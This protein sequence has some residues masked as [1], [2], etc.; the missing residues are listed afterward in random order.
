MYC[1][2]DFGTSNSTVAMADADR[3]WLI[4]L[5]D[6]HVT[7]PSAVFWDSEGAPPE[8]GRAGIAAYVR[9]DDGRLMRGLKSTLGSSLIDEKTRV[10]ARTVSFKDVLGRFFQHLHARM[11]AEAGPIRQV[12]L[13][14]PVH[15]VDDDAAGDAKA[16]GVLEDIAKA[17][18]FAEVAF[19]FEPIAA[20]LQYE[21]SVAR[22][23]LVLIVD[24]G[25]GT[26]D[27]SI[28]RVSPDRSRAVDRAGDILANDGIRV[29]GTDFD[30]LLSLS[31]VMPTLGFKASTGGG[32]GLMPNHYFLDLATWHRINMLYTQ[33]CLTD[34]KA[35]RHVVDRVELLDR[36]VKV[37]TERHGHSIAMAV[38]VAKI[39][40]SD[41]DA[42]RVALSA[43][44]GGPN[45]MATRA[46]F[47][48][49]VAAPV[50]RISAMLGSVLVQAGLRAADI[51][52]VFMTG[53]SSGLPVLRACVQA[54]LPGVA[55]AT[56]DMLGS[57]G[58][59]LAL[60]A[61]RKFG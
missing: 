59:G 51:G 57:V 56:G 23:E 60:D 17:T 39:A 5:E 29:G 53:G 3:A 35:L 54:A 55:I 1:G 36:L 13:G 45:P 34:L 4:G 7:L 41:Q 10:G 12:V 14:R 19:Q 47:D 52:T 25:G 48:E 16:Q 9:G 38:E 2:I 28:V 24:I 58:T 31:E 50:A 8:F 61:R 42:A 44:T 22:E 49:A 37:V 40:L 21:Q 32:K 46:R 27:F 30:R 43:F 11:A 20:A 6:G 26:S 15:F 18:G 33:R